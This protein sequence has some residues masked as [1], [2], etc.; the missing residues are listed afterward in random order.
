MKYKYLIFDADHTLLNYI[1]DELTAFTSLY[2]EIGLPI[3]ENVLKKSRRYSEE[4]W[5]NAG[6]YKVNDENTQKNY[7]LL[8]RTHVTGVFERIFKE[9]KFEGNPN[10]A[11]ERFLKLLERE[12]TLVHG[13][14][15]TLKALQDKAEI[16]IAT[17]GLKDI[18]TGRLQAIKGLYKKAFISEE[19]GFIKP[20]PLFFEKIL[21]ELNASASECLMIGD[22][23]SSDIA[24]AKNVGM[25]ACWFS[26]GLQ[27]NMA[28][29]QPD[30]QISSLQE[31]LNIIDR[32]KF[33]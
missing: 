8:Y 18:Q 19:I 29:V 22:S 27:E 1:K 5:T 2:Q 30:Y 6:L 16:Y 32:I 25:D 14:E 15:E 17:N 4:E 23:L 33:Q 31:L 13:A 20:L 7:H 21:E 10:I 24:G 3:T 28:G 26:A 12:S 11:G 9:E